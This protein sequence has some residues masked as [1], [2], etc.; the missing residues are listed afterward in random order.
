MAPQP[1]Y[2]GLC[3]S[4]VTLGW[5]LTLSVSMSSSVKTG[6]YLPPRFDKVK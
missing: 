3:P 2:L 6:V 5:F 1:G 4:C